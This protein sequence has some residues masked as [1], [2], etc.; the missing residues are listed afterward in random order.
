MRRWLV[1][2]AGLALVAGLVGAA[3]VWQYRVSR[4]AYRLRR[5]Q[6]VLLRG[7]WN[8]AHERADRLEASGY[9]DHAHLL[10]GQI[11]LH[12]GRV[13]RAIRE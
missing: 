8:A 12:Q 1:G 11:Y 5:G 3:A 10:R 2:L 7:D 13:D 9:P 6:E 4:P